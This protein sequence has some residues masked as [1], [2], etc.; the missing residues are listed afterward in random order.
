MIGLILLG[1]HSCFGDGFSVCRWQWG[2]YLCQRL[3]HGGDAGA[4]VFFVSP[5]CFLD[6]I[7]FVVLT[8]SV[9]CPPLAA[10]GFG[11]SVFGFGIY[12]ISSSRW[13]RS[14]AAGFIFRD[15]VPDGQVD[16]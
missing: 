4:S 13:R 11:F 7:F 5:G 14:A 1:E 3:G 2:N 10:G 16:L 6:G 9:V 8:D 12:R 15:P